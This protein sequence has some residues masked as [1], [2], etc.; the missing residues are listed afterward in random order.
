MNKLTIVIDAENINGAYFLFECEGRETE[1]PSFKSL[2][3]K[4][5]KYI[6]DYAKDHVEWITKKSVDSI[7]FFY[8]EVVEENYER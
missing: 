5:Q 6:E 3:G 4:D 7:E 8:E 1:L 2:V